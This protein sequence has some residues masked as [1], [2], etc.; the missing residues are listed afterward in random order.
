[1]KKLHK[2]AF[3]KVHEKIEGGRVQLELVQQQL[4]NDKSNISLQSQEA[5]H[6]KQLKKWSFV[7]ES[8]LK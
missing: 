7:E 4:S 6:M 2:Q 8:S 5:K 1:M 3:T